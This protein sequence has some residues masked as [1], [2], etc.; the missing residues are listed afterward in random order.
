[1][2]FEQVCQMQL[3]AVDDD[4]CEPNRR[5]VT[6]GNVVHLKAM[7]GKTERRNGSARGTLRQIDLRACL[8]NILYEKRVKT[9]NSIAVAFKHHYTSGTGQ[10][11]RWWSGG[12]H[13]WR[14]L[15]GKASKETLWVSKATQET[16]VKKE[17]YCQG[18][19]WR[20]ES[21]KRHTNPLGGCFY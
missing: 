8:L 4:A 5:E 16:A 9:K 21:G 11:M 18:G 10:T 13:R 6:W 17:G 1:M 2:Q 7:Q 15:A 3:G 12:W 20:I 19:W 14:R